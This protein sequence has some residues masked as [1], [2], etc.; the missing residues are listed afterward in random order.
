MS[1]TRLAPEGAPIAYEKYMSSPEFAETRGIPGTAVAAKAQLY[2][3]GPERDL[4]FF[5]QSLSMKQGA[6]QKFAQDLAKTLRGNAN[7]IRRFLT[8]LCIN[9]KI[10]VQFSEE[11]K[12]E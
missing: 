7:E 12:K 5:V 6:L 10:S 3:A 8:E 2:S 9:P 1:S 11:G 4:L